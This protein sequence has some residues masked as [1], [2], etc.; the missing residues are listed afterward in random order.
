MTTSKKNLRINFILS[1]FLKKYLIFNSVVLFLASLYTLVIGPNILLLGSDFIALFSGIKLYIQNPGRLYDFQAQF[2]IQNIHMPAQLNGTFLPYVY[3]PYFA[4]IFSFLYLVPFLYAKMIFIL[5]GL[6]FIYISFLAI[7][8]FS[9]SEESVTSKKYFFLYYVTLLPNFI[10]IFSGQTTQLVFT[11]LVFVIILYLKNKKFF[12]AICLTFL[13][14]KPQY[15]LIA[16]ICFFFLGEIRL[17]LYCFF[18]ASVVYFLTAL[19][20][21]NTLWLLDYVLFIKQY[22]FYEAFYNSSNKISLY[23]LS[24][25]SSVSCVLYLVALLGYVYAF[26]RVRV[27]ALMPILILLFSPHS[28]YYDFGICIIPL[29]FMKEYIKNNMLVYILIQIF[30]VCIFFIK[31]TAFF[32]VS[33]IFLIALIYIHLV[34]YLHTNYSRN[35]ST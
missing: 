26:I 10:S 2:E 31:E 18:N 35:L 21:G 27:V 32:Q 5:I 33:F 19:D 13:L 11:A 14:L 23:A 6:L 1:R 34:T 24:N 25:A 29:Y 8:N 16:V 7:D 30:T 15:Y 12:A 28:M 4:K 17:L 22:S 9:V 20:C 3:P